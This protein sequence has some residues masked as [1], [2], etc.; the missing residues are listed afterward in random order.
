MAKKE[1]E[2]EFLGH[3]WKG[4]DE[5]GYRY[6]KWKLYP[7]DETDGCLFDLYYDEGP[8]KNDQIEIR[9]YGRTPKEALA[10]LKRQLE[11]VS[12]LLGAWV[13]T[14]AKGSPK[15]RSRS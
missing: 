11:K 6:L 9:G 13:L 10:D 7:Y 1:A 4:S 15:R 5:K 2:L 3:K 12:K 8:R 14:P